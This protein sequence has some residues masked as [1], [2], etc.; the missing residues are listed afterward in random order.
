[1]GEQNSVEVPQKAWYGDSTLE[2]TFPESW[3]MTVHRMK[4][5]GKPAL[6]D[7][8]IRNAFLN[9]IGT[10]RISELA[11]GKKEVVILF[12]DLTRPTP[13][14]RVI[15]FV[16][17]ELHAGGISDEHIRFVAAIGT[18][19]LL[20]RDDF[21]KK[22]GKDIVERYPIYNHNIYENCVDV[23]TTSRGTPVQINK[24]VMSCDLK[25]GIG[26]CKP[27]SFAGFGG[28]GKIILPGVSSI[29]T[30]S[31]NHRKIGGLGTSRVN[32][33]LGL[34]KVV[35]NEVRSDIEEAARLAHLDVKIDIVM[36]NKREAVGVFVGDFVEEHRKACLLGREIYATEMAKEAD[37]VV[38]NSY[39]QEYEPLPAFWP[40]GRSLKMGG[41]V[42]LI[43]QS[44]RGLVPYYL[45]GRFG[46]NYG[47]RC[48]EAHEYKPVPKAKKIFV[49]AE[50]TSKNERDWIGPSES[51]LWYKS[52]DELIKELKSI[53]GEKARVA[54]YPYAPIQC[55]QIPA[56]WIEKAH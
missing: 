17:D 37:V 26:G 28:G 13:V 35:G 9:P 40:A 2:L 3:I 47:G 8:E 33:T 39:P 53:V 44:V 29:E 6:S 18:H 19:V 15:P 12:D 51:I 34:G 23:G 4:G 52:W 49:F 20:S 38:V 42:I 24:E 31:H 5:H 11:K 25:I 14:H 56:E 32:P 46:T 27:L 55:P 1:M 30:I 45:E 16:L 10:P 7:E 22:L 41:Y 50:H 43:Y 36:N 48:Y 54:V 21:E